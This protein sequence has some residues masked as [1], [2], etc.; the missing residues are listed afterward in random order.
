M[1]GMFG[2]K[3]SSAYGDEVD[4]DNIWAK[5]LAGLSQKD[6]NRGIKQVGES[7]MEWPPTAPEFRKLCVT[8]TREELDQLM[9]NNQIALPK[10][11]SKE[12]S[13][14]WI[15]IIKKDLKRSI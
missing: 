2:R 11:A 10:P 1:A 3:W 5:V 14:K 8:M 12:V 9:E 4:P 6:I 7:G 13:A 15:A